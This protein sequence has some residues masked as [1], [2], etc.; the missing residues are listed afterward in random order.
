MVVLQDMMVKNSWACGGNDVQTASWE[1]KK[2]HPYNN[3][4]PVSHFPPQII[5][6][7]RLT[8]GTL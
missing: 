3:K 8:T 5:S 4:D 7:F 6:H 1:D 2:L